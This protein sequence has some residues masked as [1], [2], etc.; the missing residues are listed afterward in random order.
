MIKNRIERKK[1][2]KTLHHVTLL[3]NFAFMDRKREILF[4]EQYFLDFAGKLPQKAKDKI[5]YVL[6]LITVSERI[7]VKF[8]KHIEWNRR[9]I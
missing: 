3:V 2:N 6:Y 7:P 1:E 5:A 4:F 8:F 9:I